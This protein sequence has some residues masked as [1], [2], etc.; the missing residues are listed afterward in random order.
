MKPD[1][2][3]NPKPS[4]L[5]DSAPTNIVTQPGWIFNFNHSTFQTFTQY[6]SESGKI[7]STKNS[8]S[9]KALIS[10]IFHPMEKNIYMDIDICNAVG[11]V[12]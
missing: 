9:N 4:G 1:Q 12:F 11:K 7:L 3:S 8:V 6:L 10:S 5:Q 2:E